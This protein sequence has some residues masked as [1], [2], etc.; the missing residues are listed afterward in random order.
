MT[1][2]SIG[3][4]IVIGF[5]WCWQLAL[6]Q[7]GMLPFMGAATGVQMAI[8]QGNFGGKKKD[9]GTSGAIVG[10]AI[11]SIRTVLSAGLVEN[12]TNRYQQA[13]AGS[14]DK[15]ASKSFFSGMAFGLSISIQLLN[16]AL[17][18]YFGGWLVDNKGISFDDFYVCLMAVL[19]G[20]FGLGAASANLSGADEARRAFNNVFRLLDRQTKI[21]PS[22]ASGLTLE[23]PE[24]AL[25]M[26]K[27]DFTYPSRL[28]TKVCDGYSLAIKAGMTVGLVGPSGS[29]KSTAI[30]LFERFYDPGCPIFC[31]IISIF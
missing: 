30:A 19:F 15:Y 26:D 6:I 21:D 7:I 10:E 31:L 5:V 18:F 25:A 24:G 1:L 17:I 8:I 27:V 11:R 12:L 22:L 9:D 4:G 14:L 3:M 23:A 29:G 2:F 28:D 13:T 20:T 16:N